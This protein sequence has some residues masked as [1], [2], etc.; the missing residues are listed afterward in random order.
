MYASERKV[1]EECIEE[2]KRL[3]ATREELQTAFAKC[4]AC[5][6]ET[7][8]QYCN[9]EVY[10]YVIVD[11]TGETIDSLWGMMPYARCKTE[12]REAMA[13]AVEEARTAFAARTSATPWFELVA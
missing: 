12:G 2:S 4:V 1:R 6:V 13:S 3:T 7:Y 8:G 10:G 11:S 9:S 5:E